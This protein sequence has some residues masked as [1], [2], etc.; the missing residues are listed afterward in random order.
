MSSLDEAVLRAGDVLIEQAKDAEN[1]LFTVFSQKDGKVRMEMQI[2]DFPPDDFINA[3]SLFVQA[4]S[5]Q[6]LKAAKEHNAVE[7]LPLA[8]DLFDRLRNNGKEGADEVVDE[9]N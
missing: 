3:T 5:E 8:Q 9:T 1:F 6:H 4:L 2:H 7:R